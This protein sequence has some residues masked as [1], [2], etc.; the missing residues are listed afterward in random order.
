VS[1]A[2]AVDPGYLAPFS[3][4]GPTRDGRRKP[5]IAAPGSAIASTTTFDS[6][7]TCPPSAV[8]SPLLPDGLQHREN[9]GTSM[10]APH[11]TGAAA[12]LLQKFGPLTPAFVKS[13]LATF[14]VRDIFTGDGWNKDWGHGKLFLGDLTD[15]AVA[16]LSPNGGETLSVGASVNLR[17]VAPDR[18]VTVDLLL[19]RDG[20][21]TFETIALGLPNTGS[22][23]W[24]V[25]GP[26]TGSARLRVVAYDGAGNSVED[27]S[28]G[29]FIIVGD[30][31]G[32]AGRD[33]AF[34]LSAL[35]R[36][37]TRGPARFQYAVA[38]EA[39]VRLS[40]LDVQGRV[41]ATLAEGRRPPGRY[42]AVWDG[43]SRH[44]PAGSGLY[45][46]RYR[47]PAGDFVRRIV[48]TR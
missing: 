22:Y 14:A 40:V 1:F 45:L 12:L 6:S 16:V 35:S 28:D 13:Y 3:S 32:M 39:E 25:G 30:V 5:D 10:A 29:S 37:P 15:P 18:D 41:L 11:V 31:T 34:A 4:P 46:V 36:N 43:R 19:S 38:R 44:G 42:Q 47:T 21:G 8:G 17:W 7:P 24:T 20:G 33:A 23:A 48:L 2:G 27:L 9:Q 26:P